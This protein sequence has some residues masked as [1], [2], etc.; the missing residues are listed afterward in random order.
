MIRT[1]LRKLQEKDK[2]REGGGCVGFKHGSHHFDALRSVA[3]D[4]DLH[5]GA[6]GKWQPGIADGADPLLAE[7][8]VQLGEEDEVVG[9]CEDEI[10]IELGVGEVEIAIWKQKSVA[11]VAIVIELQGGI[12]A[13]AAEGSFDRSGEAAGGELCGEEARVGRALERSTADKG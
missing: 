7:K 6:D 12:I 5:S 10:E 1:N 13:A 9:G 4:F 2:F 3:K 11:T 8:I